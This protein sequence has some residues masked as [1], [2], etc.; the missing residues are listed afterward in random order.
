MF[1]IKSIVQTVKSLFNKTTLNSLAKDTKFVQRSSSKLKGYEFI[2][3]MVVD[4]LEDPDT[5]YEALCERIAELNP[6]ANISPQALEQRVNSK[7]GVEYLKAVL[8]DTLKE[9]MN[10][11]TAHVAPKL[12]ESFNHVYLEDSTQIE[13]NEKLAKEFKGSGGSASKSSIKIDLIYDIKHSAIDNIEI[14]EGSVSDQSK[15][16]LIS[17][18]MS[19][20]DLAIRDLGYFKVES[21]RIID[22]ECQAYYLSRLFKSVNVYLEEDDKEPIDLLGYLKK[23]YANSGIIDLNVY[24]GKEEKLPCRL[25]VYR[26]PEQ[27]VNERRRKAKKAF[28]RNGKTPNKDYLDWLEFGFYITNVSNEI[29]TAEAIG[30][31]YRVRWQIELIFKNWKSLLNIDAIKG[32]RAERVQ[33]LIYGRLIAIA[34]INTIYGNMYS[35]AYYEHGR[36]L[37]AHKL[38]NWIKRKGRFSMIFSGELC[39]SVLKNMESKALRLCKQKKRKTTF[40]LLNNEI[41]YMDSF[42]LALQIIEK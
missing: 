39:G 23:Y 17:K 13:L 29:W 3:V 7:G 9:C 1:K 20:G 10:A 14:S 5:S 4:M 37:S 38:I 15:A 27:V 11:S 35:H 26:L 41:G 40:W 25:I 18:S 32:T 19:K 6:N 21:L 16:N 33:C 2:E 31:I 22:K 28:S 24:I 12:L 42:V 30:T 36:E 8:E 34:L